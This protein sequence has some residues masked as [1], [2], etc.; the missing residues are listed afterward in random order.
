M[1]VENRPASP[2]TVAGTKRKRATEPK[3]Y[4]VR[5]GREP[6]IYKTWDECLSQVKGHK[7]ASCQYYWRLCAITPT[8][9]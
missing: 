6:G 2:P 7:N 4:A 8:D 1:D 5:I 9:Y 3:L